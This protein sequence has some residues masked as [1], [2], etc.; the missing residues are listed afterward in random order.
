MNLDAPI[1]ELP[2]DMLV[3]AGFV[4]YGVPPEDRNA[5]AV[6]I[7]DKQ[8]SMIFA[9]SSEIRELL[10]KKQDT[11][12]LITPTCRD[13]IQA[14][15]E[16]CMEEEYI[17]GLAKAIEHDFHTE[18]F[19]IQVVDVWLQGYAYRRRKGVFCRQI[20]FEF[21]KDGVEDGEHVAKCVARYRR[22]QILFRHPMPNY[23]VS[24]GA[25]AR[26]FRLTG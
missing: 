12:H 19:P 3:F 14:H 20:A 4:F 18:D 11:P 21:P 9:V 5:D 13:R 2:R 1:S 7:K 16:R 22:Q 24:A 6:V 23:E 17:V 25:S 26:D 10:Q 8:I 15:I